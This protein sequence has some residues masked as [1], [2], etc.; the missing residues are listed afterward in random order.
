MYYVHW[1]RGARTIK[2]KAQG[3]AAHPV[4]FSM[5]ACIFCFYYFSAFCFVFSAQHALHKKA[6]N[7]SFCCWPPPQLASKSGL[8]QAHSCVNVWVL[9]SGHQ[10]EGIIKP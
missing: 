1:S 4:L 7:R 3:P 9:G 2:K 8:L 5:H 6:G 10:K